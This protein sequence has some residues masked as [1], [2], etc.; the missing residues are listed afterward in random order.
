MLSSPARAAAQDAPRT[1]PEVGSPAEAVYGIP[2]EEARRDAAPGILP[3]ATVRS[4]RGVGSS[5]RV[6]GGGGDGS[7]DESEVAPEVTTER[8]RQRLRQAARAAER[9]SGEPSAAATVTLLV[10]VVGTAAVGGVGVA[11]LVGSRYRL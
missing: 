11:R 6:P 4:D 1:D 2:L 10:L 5:A 3:D 8:Q 9:V 7:A